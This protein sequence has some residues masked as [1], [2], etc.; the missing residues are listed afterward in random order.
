MTIM[1]P[2]AE[3]F[4]PDVETAAADVCPVVSWTPDP[5]VSEND[6]PLT[7]TGNAEFFAARHGARVRFD[8]ARTQ[9]FGF[10]GH[11]FTRNQTGEVDR[12]ALEPSDSDRPTRS[13]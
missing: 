10:S 11:R 4:D 6:F 9:W 7:D 1:P 8:Y 5:A 13:P 3:I 2:G 12:L